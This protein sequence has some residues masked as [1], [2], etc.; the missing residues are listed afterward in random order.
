MTVMLEAAP[1]LPQ[2]Y[3]ET[4]EETLARLVEIANQ[5]TDPLFGR[6]INS[7]YDRAE[8]QPVLFYDTVKR[9]R[10]DP[11]LTAPSAPEEPDSKP[12]VQPV[13]EGPDPMRSTKTDL[14]FAEF[15]AIGRQELR[16]VQLEGSR[17]RRE[18]W[19]RRTATRVGVLCMSFAVAAPLIEVF[20]SRR[21]S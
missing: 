2:F 8:V 7:P 18:S 14:K 17:H 10:I 21:A 13:A 11:C 19:V 1:E 15:T 16:N 9:A 12:Q 6:R 5:Q 3:V 4:P 20:S